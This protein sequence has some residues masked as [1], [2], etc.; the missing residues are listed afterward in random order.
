MKPSTVNVKI[1]KR[2]AY[3]LA[4]A[5]WR[6]NF[7]NFDFEKV[8]QGRRVQLSHWYPSMANAK[9]YKSFPH[10]FVLALTVLEILIFLISDL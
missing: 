9:I 10:I 5:L 8:G 6:L 4:L 3:I 2:L 1:Y 7:F